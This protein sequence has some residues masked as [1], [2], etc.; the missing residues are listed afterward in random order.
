MNVPHNNNLT[1]YWVKILTCY[2][3][4]GEYYQQNEKE[5]TCG[6]R[7]DTLLKTSPCK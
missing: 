3:A 7:E 4:A 1:V 2:L 5:D 6:H